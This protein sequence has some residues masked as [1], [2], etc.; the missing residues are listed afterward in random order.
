[1]LLL[2]MP[3]NHIKFSSGLRRV[4]KTR[5]M[6]LAELSRKSGVPRSHIYRMLSDDAEPRW[7]HVLG[8]CRALECHPWDFYLYG[9]ADEVH[10]DDTSFEVTQVLQRLGPNGRER[11]LRFAE[12]ELELLEP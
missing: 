11:V 7:R 1:M 9:S 5:G 8:L 6:P 2:L 12:F 3:S 4:L 10:L